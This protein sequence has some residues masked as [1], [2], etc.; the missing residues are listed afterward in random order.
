[1]L[2]KASPEVRNALQENHL[3]DLLTR[4]GEQVN[5]MNKI[6]LDLQDYSKPLKP[7][8]I[9]ASLLDLINDTIST[10]TIPESVKVNIKVPEDFPKVPMDSSMIKRVFV[11]LVANA[12]QA[13]LDGGELIIE[14]FIADDA[15]TVNVQDT[16]VGIPKEN[17]DKLFQPLFTTKS[18]GQGFG[19][20][21]CRRLVEAHGGT[22]SVESEIGKGSAFTIKLPIRKLKYTQ[23]D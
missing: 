20:A 15:V 6:I 21:V 16:G 9:E 8:I 7:N 2:K 11:N 1:M 17:L 10:I 14:P 23:D 5:Y 4:I 22:I 19:L 3:E 13:M 18:K 12:M